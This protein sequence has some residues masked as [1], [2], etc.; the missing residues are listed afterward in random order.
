MSHNVKLTYNFAKTNPSVF[1]RIVFISI[2]S[3]FLLSYVSIDAFAATEDSVEQIY[4]SS[5]EQTEPTNISSLPDVK[6]EDIQMAQKR[7]IAEEERLAEI[8][9]KLALRQEHVNR[10]NN[11]LVRKRSPIAN[12]SIPGLIYDLSETYSTDYKVLLA[13]MG[14]ESGF[15]AQDYYYNCFGFI[16]KVK[17]ASYEAAF[18]DLIPKVARKYVNIYGTNFVALAKSY[19]IVN[20][21]AGSANLSMYYHQI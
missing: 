4:I 21:E 7:K 16:N 2:V 11:F 12:T 14:V 20:W 19:G 10:I 13:I 18:R 8:Q 9:R 17:Y 15:C 1:L 3:L 6:S 5:P